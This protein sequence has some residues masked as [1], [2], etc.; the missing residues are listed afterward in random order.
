MDTS[1]EEPIKKNAR[2]ILRHDGGKDNVFCTT[3]VSIVAC[4]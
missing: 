2:R 1:T 4:E 3:S